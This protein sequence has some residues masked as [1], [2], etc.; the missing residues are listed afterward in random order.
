MSQTNLLLWGCHFRCIEHFTSQWLWF[1]GKVNLFYTFCNKATQYWPPMW[2]QTFF[3]NIPAS[4]WLGYVNWYNQIRISCI[5]Y[6]IHLPSISEGTTACTFNMF[7]LLNHITFM[8]TL[9]GQ[10][11]LFC[12]RLAYLIDCVNR[13]KL[14]PAFSIRIT[15]PIL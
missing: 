8:V 12:N 11:M 13:I 7:S 3:H 10:I 4:R 15:Y 14:W 1:G 2:H 9:W 6:R 5:V